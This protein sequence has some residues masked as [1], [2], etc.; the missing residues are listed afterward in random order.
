VKTLGLVLAASLAAGCQVTD[1]DLANGA[2]VSFDLTPA[3][4]STDRFTID[5]DGQ[6]TAGFT[7]PQPATLT[8]TVDGQPVVEQAIDLSAQ[9]SQDLHLTIPL[10]AAGPNEISASV[11]Y[12]DAQLSADSTVTVG[13]TAPTITV[14]DLTQ[15]YTPNVGLDATGTITVAA[16]NG[17]AVDAVETSVDDGPWQ[18]ATADG[19]GGWAVDLFDPD[20]GTVDVAV[21][22][23]VSI[24]GHADQTI[25]HK[26]M[27]VAPRFDCDDSTLMLPSEMLLSRNVENRVMVGYFGLPGRGHDVTF[28]L[29]GVATNLP[30]SPTVTVASQTVDYGTTQMHVAI[31]TDPLRC[32]DTGGTFCDTPYDL[33]VLVDGV[34]LCT[35]T[36]VSQYGVIRRY[37]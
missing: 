13:M 19:S 15:T 34:E 28:E 11:A 17:Y 33:T 32:A 20:I 35:T 7:S 6:V 18:P 26:A 36:N 2:L 14:P 27:T 9:L 12:H 16:A 31:S 30:G 4:T 1:A 37:F 3:A 21:R 23:T 29:T 8:V 25:V 22:A 24:D 5:L 10:D